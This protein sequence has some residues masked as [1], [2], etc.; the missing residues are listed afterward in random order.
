MRHSVSFQRCLKDVAVCWTA[1]HWARGNVNPIVDASKAG[2]C[3]RYIND[4]KGFPQKGKRPNVTAVEILDHSTSEI[5][6]F[7][8]TIVKVK[9]GEELLLD[10][11]NV[12]P[13]PAGNWNFARNKILHAS[14][15]AAVCHFNI[16]NGLFWSGALGCHRLH[17]IG[18][19]SN[20]II[21]HV[22]ERSY[23]LPS[24][25]ADL[26]GQH[27]CEGHLSR[28]DCGAFQAMT[29]L[30]PSLAVCLRCVV[31]SLVDESAI[32]CGHIPDLRS[33]FFFA[34]I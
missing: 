10:Y 18:E 4:P 24:D 20:N 27:G 32:P 6:I 21:L 33:T 8:I 22:H 3:L 16:L 31:R 17:N 30:H 23:M 14:V 9:K 15:K 7:I 13:F 11:G 2:N 29:W 28:E 1:G 26:L 12:S 25:A 19:F 34:T 5:H